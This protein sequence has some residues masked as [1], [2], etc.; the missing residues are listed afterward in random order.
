M[1][2][3]KINYKKFAY[4]SFTI[5]TVVILISIILKVNNLKLLPLLYLI[6]ILAM[7]YL[8]FLE[9][10]TNDGF[11]IGEN[12]VSFYKKDDLC[13]VAWEGIIAKKNIL[14]L[15]LI[16]DSENKIHIDSSKIDSVTRLASKY[17]PKDHDL[18]RRLFKK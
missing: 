13:T 17:C 7:I 12:G 8:Y 16:I 9:H 15:W 14:G 10:H 4:A 3:I 18:Y 2:K 5:I 11:Y 6:N 1:E